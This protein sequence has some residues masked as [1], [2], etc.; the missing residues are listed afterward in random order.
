MNA[1]TLLTDDARERATFASLAATL[2]LPCTSAGPKNRLRSV[3][4]IATPHG[5]YFL[6]TFVRT[7]W[8]NRVRFLATAPRA[9]DDAERERRVADALRAAG[10]R[11]P[12][13]VAHGRRGAFAFLLCAE[14]PGTA[15]RERLRI[16][17][18]AALLRAVARH[19]GELLAAG[20]WLPDL[21][22]EHV[23]VHGGELAVLDLHNGRLARVGPAPR[24]LLAR[25]LRRFRRS[26]LDL[27]VPRAPALRFAARLLHAARCRD[28]RAVL[29]AQPPWA[30]AARYDAPGKSAAYAERSPAR[31]AREQ[32]LLR[33]VWPGRRGESVLD[34]PCGAGR[35]L[36]LL[37]DEL[38]HRV[39]HADGSLAMLREARARAP[40]PAPAVLGN[41]LALPFADGAVDGVVMFR[42]L[43]HLPRDAAW[44]ALAEACRVARRFVVVSFFHPC[45]AHGAS[46][47]VSAWLGAP[48][49]RFSTTLGALRAHAAKHG[50]ALAAAAAERAFV[51]DLWLAAFERESTA[52]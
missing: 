40:R 45:S 33:R 14:L 4:R 26:V 11:A 46:R 1:W 24:W 27:G 15:L 23:F 18:D 17:I 6:K 51:R 34:L 13:I 2:A 25:V 43:H 39:V 36:P 19:C 20:F 3:T 10:H 31:S 50:F 37:R 48:P 9:R 5:V 52:T 28:V 21:S 35:L 49:T 8:Q 32:A 47:L 12:R 38:G 42:F 7:Q 30:T 22:A 16:A 29:R 44:Q 41:A